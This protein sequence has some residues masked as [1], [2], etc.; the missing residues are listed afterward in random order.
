MDDRLSV[1]YD[2]N[3]R[4]DGK[5]LWT[6]VLPLPYRGK[7]KDGFLVV[8]PPELET[9]LRVG[10]SIIERAIEGFYR[11]QYTRLTPKGYT[12]IPPSIW[13]AQLGPSRQTDG[14]NSEVYSEKGYENGG[15]HWEVEEQRPAFEQH[16][17]AA[18]RAGF[19]PHV[20]E[21]EN[22]AFLMLRNDEER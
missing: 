19:H 1:V 2:N 21:S 16:W 14:S 15:V 13:V 11:E 22:D 8:S 12:V 4:Y 5:T 10:H 20:K 9:L 6:D 7:R 18:E 3:L 17:R